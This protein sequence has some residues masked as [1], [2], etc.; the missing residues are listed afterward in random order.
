MIITKTLTAVILY[1][2]QQDS[3]GRLLYMNDF[4][5]QHNDTH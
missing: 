4:T 3:H 1:M 2:K 5:V